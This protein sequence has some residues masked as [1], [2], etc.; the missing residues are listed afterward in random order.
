LDCDVEFHSEGY[1]TKGTYMYIYKC[2]VPVLAA[3]AL[4]ACTLSTASHS[5]RPDIYGNTAYAPGTAPQ[6]YQVQG[7]QPQGYQPQGYQTT[8]VYNPPQGTVYQQPANARQSAQAPTTGQWQWGT[9]PDGHRT[10]I[11]IPDNSWKQDY[12]QTAYVPPAYQPPRSSELYRASRGRYDTIRYP[13]GRIE[14]E[15][16][17]DE[18][19]TPL[20]GYWQITQAP[21]GAQRVWVTGVEGTAAER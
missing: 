6:A 8:G 20:Q 21:N 4:G 10:R 11:W 15:W 9:T 17:A 19:S 14:H 3:A 5:D 2:F 18:P 7:Y 1:F 12:G 13:D 16:R